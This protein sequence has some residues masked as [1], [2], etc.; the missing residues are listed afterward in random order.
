MMAF[1]EWAARVPEY[2]R[3]E[4]HAFA[5]GV[6][7]CAAGL[8]AVALARSVYVIVRESRR[9]KISKWSAWH[10]LDASAR[11]KSQVVL[12][13]KLAGDS[14]PF[15]PNETPVFQVV[16]TGGQCAGKASSIEFLAAELHKDGWNVYTV[17]EVPT[18]LMNGGC[19]YPGQ[20]G[21]VDALVTFESR[22]L[23]LQLQMEHSFTDIARSSRLPSIILYD[24]ALPDV[25]AFL[26]PELWGRVLNVNSWVR[27]GLLSV[28]DRYDLILHLVTAADGAETF[29]LDKHPDATE[30]ELEEARRLD[31]AVLDSYRGHPHQRVIDN[32]QNFDAKL[33]RVYEHLKEVLDAELQQIAA[34]S[35]AASSRSM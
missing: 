19:V 22:L 4:R 23:E 31:S 30:E 33:A 21:D 16:I 13:N 17:P 7:A 24:R 26:P 8:S 35:A 6:A 25:A 9:R 27:N 12:Q 34:A 2:G 1:M 32:A 28:L 20:D 14:A 29:Y 10:H 15:A 3:E 18:L 11:E 5:V